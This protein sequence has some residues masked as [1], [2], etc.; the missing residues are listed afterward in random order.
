MEASLLLETDECVTWPFSRNRDGYPSGQKHRWVCEKVN[1]PSP[2][3]RHVAAH[4]CDRGHE[5]CINKRHLEWKTHAENMRDKRQRREL[6]RNFA[7]VLMV[8]RLAKLLD[9]ADTEMVSWVRK[10]PRRL[11][12]RAMR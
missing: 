4:S 2:S 8:E 9:P 11:N 5:G 10:L 12:G 3:A 7:D 6:T 1:G